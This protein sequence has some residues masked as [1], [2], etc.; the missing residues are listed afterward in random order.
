MLKPGARDHT[1]KVTGSLMWYVAGKASPE[2][3]NLAFYR[4]IGSEPYDD[5]YAMRL[6]SHVEPFLISE[7][8]RATGL[9]IVRRQEEVPLP[10]LEEHCFATIDGVIADEVAWLDGQGVITEFKFAGAHWTREGLLD[11]YC[12]QVMLQMM[13]TGAARGLLIVGQGTAELLELEVVRDKAYEAELREHIAH[14]LD[15]VR[16]LTPPHPE[17]IPLPPPTRWRT[18]D[19]FGDDAPNWAGECHTHLQVYALTKDA[20]A[21]HTDAGKAARAL[22]PD[23]VGTVLAGDWRIN[24]NKRG[25]LTINVNK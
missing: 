17:P 7:Y 25:V 15:C 2:A 9:T 13:C 19:I 12:D 10:G 3:T 21:Q 11:R 5:T 6:G 14:W 22:V 24:R 16:T 4:C 23:D 20:A 18:V 1:G 8:Q